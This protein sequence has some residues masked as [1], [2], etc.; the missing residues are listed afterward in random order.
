MRRAQSF[1][2]LLISLGAT[3]G[4]TNAVAQAPLF[5]CRVEGRFATLRGPAPA[6]FTTV[7]P[8][9]RESEGRFIFD[10]ESGLLRWRDREIMMP[11]SARFDVTKRGNDTSHDWFGSLSNGFETATLRIRAWTQPPRFALT[12]FNGNLLVGVCS[13]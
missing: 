11:V 8:G 7:P 12:D 9:Q 3:G 6:P 13:R 2:L 5:E 1:M 4:A 10:A